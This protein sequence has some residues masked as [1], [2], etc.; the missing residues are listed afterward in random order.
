MS[1]WSRIR[2]WLGPE[3]KPKRNFVHFQRAVHAYLRSRGLDIADTSNQDSEHWG[4]VPLG[5]A[6]I[7]FDQESRRIA[8]NRAR[9]ETT[10]NPHLRG[11]VNT[12]SQDVIGCGPTLQ[13]HERHQD[14]ERAWNSWAQEVCLSEKLM[15]LWGDGKIQDGE[16]IALLI[17]NPTV[18]H[19]V[20]L[21]LMPIEAEQMGNPYAQADTEDIYDG[22][23]H[24]NGIPTAYYIYDYHPDLYSGVF[25]L[26]LPYSGQWYERD[27]VIHVFRRWRLGQLRGATELASALPLSAILRRYTMATL[28]SAEVAASISLWLETD[29]MPEEEPS[30]YAEPFETMPVTRNQV[31]TAPYR[32]K[33]HQLKAEQ[34]VDTYDKFLRA[35]VT[36]MGRAIGM[37]AALSYGDSSE[38]NMASGR[39]DYQDYIRGI[40]AERR[41]FLENQCVDKIFYQWLRIYLSAKT[42]FGP[43]DF[44]SQVLRTE[45]GHRWTYQPIHHSDPEKQANADVKLHERGLLTDIDLLH[46]MNKD[47]EQHMEELKRQ[48]EFRREAGIPIPGMMPGMPGTTP[49]AGDSQNGQQ[50]NGQTQKASR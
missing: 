26:A 17:E 48:T 28:A 36:Q 25:T 21:D 15:E 18:D 20:Q 9:Y 11:L 50:Q 45:Y 12:K 1:M 29:G 37:P 30:A 41:V 19:E 35:I 2:S 4:R 32:W 10:N 6:N 49:D 40:E 3:E 47:P 22:I 33:I 42:N 39:L 7:A 23:R 5:D 43:S 46:R 13:M 27:R 34:P 31:I 16:G 8:R 38:Y 24:F 14:I 44:P